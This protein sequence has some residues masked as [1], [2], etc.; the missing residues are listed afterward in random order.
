MDLLDTRDWSLVKRFEMPLQRAHGVAWDGEGLWV[1]HPSDAVIVKYDADTGAQ[2]DAHE[3]PDGSP[4]PH[5]L[6]IWLGGHVVLRREVR[7]GVPGVP[8]LAQVLW[9]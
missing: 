9:F 3:L 4:E 7:R 8:E 6:T 2:M 5:G 1:S